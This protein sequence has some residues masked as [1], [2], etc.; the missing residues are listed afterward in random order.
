MPKFVLLFVIGSFFGS[1][2]GWWIGASLVYKQFQKEKARLESTI[3]K[4][5]G[6]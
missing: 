6:G 2:L 1:I 3:R 4:M 5:R